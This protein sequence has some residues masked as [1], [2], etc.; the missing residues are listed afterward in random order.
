M[1]IKRIASGNFL[2][3]NSNFRILYSCSKKFSQQILPNKSGGDGFKLQ[4]AIVNCDDQNGRVL[5]SIPFTYKPFKPKKYVFNRL[6]AEQIDKFIPLIEEKILRF[7]NMK[8]KKRHTSVE[9]LNI[10]IMKHSKEEL[11]NVSN[12]HTKSLESINNEKSIYEI[13]VGAGSSHVLNI[14]DTYYYLDVNPPQI[15]SLKLSSDIRTGCLAY[16]ELDLKNACLH[17]TKYSWYSSQESYSDEKIIY[18]KI[19]WDF[20]HEG[21]LLKVNEDL[22]GKLLK[23]IGIF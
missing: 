21:Y 8:L 13:L 17:D 14:D 7:I 6:P 11:M 15:A 5:V 23:V 9:K 1:I 4:R 10:K 18:T 16:P 22:K 3:K 19:K 12:I 2:N 20:I